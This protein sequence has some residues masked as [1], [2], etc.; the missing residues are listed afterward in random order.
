MILSTFAA[1]FML[2]HPV[3]PPRFA[4][5]QPAVD[6]APTGPLHDA[7]RLSFGTA[8]RA[9]CGASALLLEIYQTEE[10]PYSGDRSATVPLFTLR[11]GGRVAMTDASFIGSLEGWSV[12]SIMPSCDGDDVPG[13]EM[14]LSSHEDGTLLRRYWQFE[15]G[16]V[17]FFLQE[18]LT[19]MDRVRSILR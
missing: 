5:G 16:A 13:L 6:I 10:N 17:S 3:E 18:E 9:E 2:F 12:V 14:L 8:I 1:A 15:G 19:S 4:Q 11:R 7:P